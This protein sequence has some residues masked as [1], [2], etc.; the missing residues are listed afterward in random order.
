MVATLPVGWA[1]F[2][3]FAT[4]A[5]A[6]AVKQRQLAVAV[7][8]VLAVWGPAAAEDVSTLG[9]VLVTARRDVP[10]GSG[11]FILSPAEI[12]PQRART[13][14]TASLLTDHSRRERLW[15]RWGLQPAG[16]PRPGG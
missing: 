10:L 8:G 6:V 7:F 16:H 15:R 13:S 2:G 4:C 1:Y 11:S 9:E 5:E 14:D 3:N 12:A